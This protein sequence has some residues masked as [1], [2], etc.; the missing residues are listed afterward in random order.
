MAS[1]I[2]F[3]RRNWLIFN[4]PAL[5]KQDSALKFGIL[6]AA[7]IAPMALF[8][9]A[10]SHPEV[11]IYTVAARDKAKAE[12]YAKKHGIPHVSDSYEA[13]LDDP[14]VDVVYIPLPNGLHF[15]WT[16]RALAKGKHVL[17]E[18]PSTSNAAEAEI[19]FKSPSSRSP[20]RPY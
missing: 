11:I 8:I 1:V 19:L 3:L 10:K 14:E 4:P 5:K 9:P 15:E 12:A 13:I 20:M 16:L 6:G 17:L 2:G 18:K 7:N